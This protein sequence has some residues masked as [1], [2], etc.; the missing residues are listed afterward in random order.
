M[1][2][3]KAIIEIYKYS[4]TNTEYCDD[5]MSWI[6]IINQYLQTYGKPENFDETLK[7][8]IDDLSLLQQ[9]MDNELI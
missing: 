3:C 4:A 2:A 7:K 6:N 1:K 9:T 5:F 8:S